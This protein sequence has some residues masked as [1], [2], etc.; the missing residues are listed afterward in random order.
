MANSYLIKYR[1]YSLVIKIICGYYNVLINTL[2]YFQ[3]VQLI[4]Y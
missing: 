1:N 2:Q 4:Y 3:L